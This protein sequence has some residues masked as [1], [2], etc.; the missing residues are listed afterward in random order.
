MLF[1]LFADLMMRLMTYF[2][3]LDPSDSWFLGEVEAVRLA[4]GPGCG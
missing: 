3:S 4:C 2:A 1:P